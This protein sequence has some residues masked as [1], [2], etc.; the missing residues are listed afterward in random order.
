MKN[1]F[2]A[3]GI[4]FALFLAGCTG[5]FGSGS[6]AAATECAND[7]SCFVSAMQNNCT[8]AKVGVSENG[9]NA[10]LQVKGS[11]QNGSCEVLVKMTDIKKAPDMTDAVWKAIEASKGGLPLLDMTCPI[12]PEKAAGLYQQK[13]I[14]AA[15][16]VFQSCKGSLKEVAMLLVS[17]QG[18]QGEEAPVFTAGVSAFPP[19]IKSGAKA[20]IVAMGV[21]GKEPYRYDFEFGDGTSSM[22]SPD[23]T[24]Q[25][26]YSNPGNAPAIYTVKVTVRDASGAQAKAEVTVKVN[27]NASAQQAFSPYCIESDGPMQNVQIRGR[28]KQRLAN[29]TVLEY[30]DSCTSADGISEYYCGNNITYGSNPS[31]NAMVPGSHCSNGACVKNE[32]SCLDSDGFTNYWA[33][34]T[35]TTSNAQGVAASYDDYCE[36]SVLV[37]DYCQGTQAATD[38]TNC[39]NYNKTC[40]DGR[41][42]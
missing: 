19:E 37:E 14:L 7:F 12:T 8:A 1:S 21:N 35:V 25:H 41:C 6:G 26:Q 23:A 4:V 2:F 32:A 18:A 22:N 31:C 29:G 39:Q 40:T 28:Y 5:L 15:K 11:S 33:W 20:G 34:G 30:A 13:Q 10:T 3:F 42:V 17:Q 24:Q 27:A 38:I 36:G 16:E 9:V